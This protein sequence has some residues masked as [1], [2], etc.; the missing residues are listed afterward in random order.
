[1]VTVKKCRRA[2][3]RWDG[4]SYTKV[5]VPTELAAVGFMNSDSSR[6]LT[7]ER[8]SRRTVKSRKDMRGRFLSPFHFC[9]ILFA[10]RG[11]LPVKDGSS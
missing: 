10:S 3:L 8:I 6:E 9:N 4:V 2:C 7:R 5:P 11:E 1:V